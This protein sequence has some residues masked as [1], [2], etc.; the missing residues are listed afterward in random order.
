MTPKLMAVRIGHSDPF[1]AVSDEL[2]DGTGYD[3]II[4]STFPAAK[5]RWLRAGL[6]SRLEKQFG[7]PVSHVV[8]E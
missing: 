5:S 3:T 7:I 4:V 8:M 1:L 2:S 6:P